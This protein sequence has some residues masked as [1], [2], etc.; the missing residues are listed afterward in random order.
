MT[1]EQLEK[2]VKV[3]SLKP[4][5]FSPTDFEALLQSAKRR[6]VDARNETLSLDSRFDL[7]YNA[8]HALGLAALR[9]HGFRAENRYI[10]FQC[11]THTLQVQPDRWRILAD[12]HRRRNVAEYDGELDANES[13]VAGMIEVAED[14]VRRLEALGPPA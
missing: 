9:W 6:L 7:A 10:V 8:S 1:S 3:G 12:A 2:L 5:A 11:L 14:M 13:L 4:E